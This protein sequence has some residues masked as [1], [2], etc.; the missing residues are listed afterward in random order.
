MSSKAW[1]YVVFFVVATGAVYVGNY[2]YS[3]RNKA[4]IAPPDAV[5]LAPTH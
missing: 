2:L 5:T 1:H 3:L 4:R